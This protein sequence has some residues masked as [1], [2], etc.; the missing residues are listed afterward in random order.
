M[1]INEQRCSYVQCHPSWFPELF[2]GFFTDI[3]FLDF[4]SWILNTIDLFFI[5]LAAYASCE[6]CVW[7]LCLMLLFLFYCNQI[8]YLLSYISVLCCLPGQSYVELYISKFDQMKVWLSRQS[9]LKVPRITKF[10][11]NQSGITWF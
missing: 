8:V 1:Q 7:K 2:M 3:F 5:M 9:F 6:K 11:T 4:R 10:M